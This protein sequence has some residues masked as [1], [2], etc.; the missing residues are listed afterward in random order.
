[1]CYFVGV[2]DFSNLC[3]IVYFPTEDFSDAT[4]TIVNVGLYYMFLEQHSLA[5]DKA[6]KEEYEPYLQMCRVNVETALA[7][8]PLFMSA[9]VEN[10]KALFL[11]VIETCR[12]QIL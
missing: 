2:T 9:K 8:M 11:G 6:T 12:P 10:V 5:I 7:N 1:M 3:R 4:F